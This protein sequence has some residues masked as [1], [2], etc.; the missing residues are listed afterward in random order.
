[1]SDNGVH[2]LILPSSGI[3]S[4]D[5][6]K[7]KPSN[8]GPPKRYGHS[9]ASIEDRIYVVGGYGEDGELLNEK[10]RVWVF[11]TALNKWS[12]FDPS[13]EGEKPEPRAYGAAVASVHPRPVALKTEVDILPQD[14]PDPETTILE[15]PSTDSYGTLVIQGGTGSDGKHINDLW[16]FDISSRTWAPLPSP[17][18]PASTKPSLAMVSN[19][20]Y[21]F[22]VGQTSYLD[23]THGFHDDRGGRGRT[24]IVMKFAC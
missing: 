6:K 7:I 23:L 3:E 1:M 24:K 14:P 9:S 4:T 15:I 10:G 22:S 13:E 21:T 19:R 20:L 16:S 12:H 2:V 8:D 5:Y 11:N 17:P 18:P